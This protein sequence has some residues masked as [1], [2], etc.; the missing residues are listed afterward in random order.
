MQSIVMRP[1]A[2]AGSTNGWRPS[3]P[4]RPAMPVYSPRLGQ[5]AA[6]STAMPGAAATATVAAPKPA[7]IDSALVQTGFDIAGLV[8]TGILAYG[9]TYPGVS[10]R[11]APSRW[12]YFFGAISGAFVLKTLLDLSRIRTR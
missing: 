11:P 4:P 8:A 9:A 6:P 1:L 7:F 5:Q 2:L 3:A 12:A 10:P